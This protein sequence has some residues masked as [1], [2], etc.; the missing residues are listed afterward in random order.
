MQFLQMK[1]TDKA[2]RAQL[3][4]YV[5]CVDSIAYNPKEEYVSIR[6]LGTGKTSKTIMRVRNNVS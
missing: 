1:I 4:T 5:C 2:G 3:A 6:K